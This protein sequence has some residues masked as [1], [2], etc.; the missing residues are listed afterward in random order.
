LDLGER[1]VAAEV[2]LVEP[3]EG[4]GLRFLLAIGPHDPDA[5]Q[6]LVYEVGELAELVLDLQRAA[7][8]ALPE[9][10]H[11]DRESYQRQQ[12]EAGEKRADMQH[13]WNDQGRPDYCIYQIHE[14]RTGHHAHGK[15]VVRRAGHDVARGVPIVE[16]RRHPLKMVVERVPQIALDPAA[17]AVEDVA[18]EVPRHPADHG[19]AHQ[20]QGD[21]LHLRGWGGSAERV[22]A[23]LE[24]AGP[25]NVE[26][27]GHQD[28][29]HARGERAAVRPQ[30]GH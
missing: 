11:R 5:G 17:G 4:T 13:G 8:D 3:A 28:H 7:V 23:P 29:G 14:G 15:Q 1:E 9:G 22:D 12:R 16:L 30:E 27:V 24:K 19:H 20:Q 26:V 18:H 2:L 21:V 25:E 10:H 6:V